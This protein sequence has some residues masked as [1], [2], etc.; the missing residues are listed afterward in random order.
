MED[1]LKIYEAPLKAPA[2]VICLDEEPVVLHADTRPATPI[3]P[4][5]AARRDYKY[6]R[7]G[8]ANVFCVVEPKAGRHFTKVTPTRA[9][10]D[11]AEFLLDIAASYPAAETIHLVLDNL[12]THTRKAAMDWF[13]EKDGGWLRSRFTL[14]HTPKH[15]SWINQ[16][17]IQIGL[18]SR[19]C[20]GKPRISSIEELTQSS[21]PMEPAHQPRHDHHRLD[22]HTEESQTQTKVQ[23]HAVVILEQPHP[24][25]L[26]L[27]GL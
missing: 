10:P 13:G 27:H 21:R 25:F 26:C 9:S 15:R 12:S 7:C 8:T 2:P 1:V 18:F 17:E 5:H 23:T 20:L 6:K 24:L 14:P 22:L 4:G 16:A 11:F 3:G 19:Q